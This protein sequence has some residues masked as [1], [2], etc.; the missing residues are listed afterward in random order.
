MLS[1]RMTANK[2]DEKPDIQ[3]T[4]STANVMS[5]LHPAV[6]RLISEAEDAATAAD[7]DLV[8]VLC[9]TIEM[10][11]CGRAGCLCSIVVFVFRQRPHSPKHTRTREN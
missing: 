7:V 10:G 8:D 1:N 5:E 2:R 6:L 9:M 11:M 3:A 4:S